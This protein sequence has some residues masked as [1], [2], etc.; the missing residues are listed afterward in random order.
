MADVGAEK[1]RDDEALA[2]VEPSA[3]L[4]LPSEWADPTVDKFSMAF[5]RAIFAGWARQPSPCCAAASVAGACNAALGLS[6]S[7]AGALSHAHIAGLLHGMLSDQA[8]KRR[9]ALERLLGGVPIEPAIE[10]L[11]T[12]LCAEGRGLGGR[13]ELGCKP[14]EALTRLRK[15]AE[16]TQSSGEGDA[17]Q[18]AADEAAETWRALREIFA[19][20]SAADG[21]DE[22]DEGDEGG[23]SGDEA[24]LVEPSFPKAGGGASDLGVGARRELRALLAKL[25]GMEQL[26]P[27]QQ[28]LSTAMVGNWGITGAVRALREGRFHDWSADPRLADLCAGA[29]ASGSAAGAAENAPPPNHQTAELGPP[30]LHRVAQ[31]AARLSARTLASVRVRGV[32]APPIVLSKRDTEAEV[33]AA[34]LALRA[35][36]SRPRSALVLHHRNHYAL[37]FAMREWCRAPPCAEANGDAHGRTN[38]STTDGLTPGQGGEVQRVRQILSARKGQR[39]TAWLDWTEVHRTLSGWAGYAI[40]EV[41]ADAF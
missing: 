14:R 27:Q 10:A 32:P 2:R 1:D 8:A 34:W 36:F 17:P 7:D 40:I 26:S 3:E 15:L 19:T 24:L 4:L 20:S 35:A 22:G 29:L 21:P 12:Q 5:S 38:G 18:L 11:R 37:I 33:E 6:A 30:P 23:A 39:P 41:S 28:R 25:S 9:A 13:K 31:D 16:A